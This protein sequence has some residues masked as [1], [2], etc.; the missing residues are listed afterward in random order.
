MPLPSEATLATFY[1]KEFYEQE[2]PR[3]FIETK[4]DLPW[5][6]ATYTEYYKLFESLVKG[7]RLLDIGSGPGHFL[8]AGKKRAWETVGIEPSRAAANYSARRGLTTVHDFFSYDRAKSLGTFDVVHSAM[9]LEHVR[10]P[11]TFI[12]DMIKMTKR[13]GLIAIFCPNDYNPLQ[14]RLRTKHGFSPWWVVPRHHLNYFSPKSMQRLLEHAGCTIRD[15][16]GTYP[17]ETFLLGGKNYVGN[18]TLGRACHAARKAFEMREYK[19]Q[20]ELITDLYRGLI[21]AG[22]GR[23]F[24]VIAQRS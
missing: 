22:I 12:V 15:V 7:R 2:R 4:Q 5:W 24:L 9:V 10:D 11:R 1:D 6:M 13:K 17:L 3:Y 8:L 19:Q 18:H 16:I 23:E 14:E 21:Q 20:P